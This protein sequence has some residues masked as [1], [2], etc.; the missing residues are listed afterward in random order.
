MLNNIADWER[1]LLECAKASPDDKMSDSDRIM[2]LEDMCPEAIQ[3]CLPEKAPNGQIRKYNDYKD[4]IDQY[5]YEEKRWSK[6]HRPKVHLIN[7]ENAND[8]ETDP[9]TCQICEKPKISSV[10]QV[11]DQWT[12]NLLGE[13]NALVKSKIGGSKGK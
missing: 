13:I 9:H 12:T 10:V 8:T 7:E 6:S 4:A 1:R 11:D 3:R 5:Y 2:C